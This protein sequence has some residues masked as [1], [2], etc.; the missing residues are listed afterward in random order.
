[1]T[2]RRQI[3]VDGIFDIETQDWDTFVC[4][5]LLT[6]DGFRV[7]SW[8]QEDAM[9][10]AILAFSGTLWAHAGGK[11]D[12]LWLLSHIAKRQIKA[13]IFCAGDRIVCLQI[14]KLEIRDSYALVPMSLDKASEISG[15]R[16][17]KT[18]LRCDCNKDCGGYCR[19]RRDMTAKEYNR[20]ATYLRQ[21]CLANLALLDKIMEY[22]TVKDLDLS[23]TIGSAAWA[24]AARWQG[25][26]IAKWRKRDYNHARQGYY[27]G[28]VQVFRPYAKSGYRYD[29]N[30]SYPA[31]LAKTSLPVGQPE[32]RE[33]ANAKKAFDLGEPGIY[34]AEVEV[35]PC[36]I[37]V[38]PCRFKNRIGYPVGHFQGTWTQPELSYAL[39]QGARVV[40]FQSSLVW[41]KSEPILSNFAKGIWDLRHAAGKSTALGKWLKLYANSLT[42][43]LAQRPDKESAVLYPDP[44]DIVFCPASFPCRGVL[45]GD[46]PCC[47]HQCTGA[48]GRWRQLAGYSPVWL[49][50]T[51]RIP[52]SGHVQWAAYLTSVARIE[53]HKQLVSDYE[54]GDSAVYCDTDSVY[55]TRPRDYNLGDELGQWMPE[56]EFSDFQALSP[57][58]YRYRDVA[59]KKWHARA[60]GIPN[61]EEQWKAIKSGEVIRLDRGVKT[62]KTAAK[63]GKFFA[64]KDAHRHVNPEAGYFGDRMRLGATTAAMQAADIEE[65]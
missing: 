10:D 39:S 16:K 42:G 46:G 65:L 57:K 24:C 4:G 53:L 64:K 11:Y 55:A 41:P 25:L 35:P 19:I 60:K 58:V 30:S 43:K 33:Y 32:T 14:G 63:A 27:G 49:H 34:S 8:K 9:V 51:W 48:C 62:F 7:W 15:I 18:G 6:R 56:G 38:L 45:C 61:A 54:D 22:A 23:V 1:M 40:Q 17:S 21:D 52:L 44:D 28:R 31:A 12:A 13:Q 3:E 2:A 26:D 36:H 5:G 20:L 37:P 47:P 59:S 29:I 50:D